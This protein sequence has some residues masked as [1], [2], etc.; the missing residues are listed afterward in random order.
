MANVDCLDCRCGTRSSNHEVILAVNDLI[1]EVATTCEGRFANSLETVRDSSDNA[2]D[3][4]IDDL[5]G[6]CEKA[7]Q[8]LR[9]AL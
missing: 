6:T 9:V 3:T 8:L 1:S 5:S 2:L 4:V 7:F